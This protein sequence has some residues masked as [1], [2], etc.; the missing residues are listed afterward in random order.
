MFVLE[1]LGV[2]GI[3]SESVGTLPTSIVFQAWKMHD[4]AL[5]IRRQY[6]LPMLL[7]IANQFSF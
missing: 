4:N 5:T 1:L 3:V 6:V 7:H 2:L